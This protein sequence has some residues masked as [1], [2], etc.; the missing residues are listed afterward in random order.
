MGLSHA[1]KLRQQMTEAEGRLWYLL[2]A[3]RLGG[4]EFNRQALIGPYIVD[5][6]CFNRKLIIEV[7]GGQH[8]D[9]PSDRRRDEWLRGEGFRVLRF[10]NNDVLKNTDG[11]LEVISLALAEEA[12]SPSPGSLRSP[13]SP[14]RGEGKRSVLQGQ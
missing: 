9:S 12:K 11:V 3:H 10:W 8:A 7:D 6:V 2:R 4:I 5:F 1:R 13:P 14:T